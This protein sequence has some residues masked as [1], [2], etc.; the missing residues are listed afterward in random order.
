MGEID[1]NAVYEYWHDIMGDMDEEERETHKS[2]AELIR[3]I[4]EKN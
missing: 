3:E 4:F 2:N 1:Y